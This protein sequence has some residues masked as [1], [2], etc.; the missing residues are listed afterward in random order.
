MSC[1]IGP[2]VVRV[3][4]PQLAEGCSCLDSI[5]LATGR[6]KKE[7]GVEV[8][9]AKRHIQAGEFLSTHSRS[10]SSTS[11][12]FCPSCVVS[13]V[14][15]HKF[16]MILVDM[17]IFPQ[18]RTQY[19]LHLQSVFMELVEIRPSLIPGAGDGLFARKVPLPPFTLDA[20]PLMKE[21]QDIQDNCVIGVY[22]GTLL[23]MDDHCSG[24]RI[25]TFQDR[26]FYISR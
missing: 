4:N 16:Q 3:K 19:N 15:L 17:K 5:R 21:L 2:N 13:D 9:Q 25:L 12:C 22:T 20:I 18:M 7:L 8:F 6:R 1:C 11:S 23:S 10:V 14:T 24:D 26:P